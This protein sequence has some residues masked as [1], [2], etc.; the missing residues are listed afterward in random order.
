MDQIVEFDKLIFHFVN[1]VWID[2]ILDQFLAFMRNQF[3]WFPLYVFLIAY[4]VMNFGKKGWYYVLF[5]VMLVVSTNLISSELIKKSVK[6]P[7]PC[8]EKTLENNRRSLVRCG[9]GFSF[10]SS[11]ATNH[12][13]FSTFLFLTGGVFIGSWRYLFLLWAAMISYSQVYVGV[14]YPLDVIGGALLGIISAYLGSL[15]FQRISF[16]K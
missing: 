2:P 9:S 16:F 1:Q 12:F 10:T 7:R 15:L 3:V 14:H 5:S 6:R 13:S 8:N 11:H 4:L